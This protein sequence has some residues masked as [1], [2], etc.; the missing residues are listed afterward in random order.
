MVT[1][2]HD[3]FDTR[4]FHKEIAS[5]SKKP[6]LDLTM[7][8]C[9]GLGDT[10]IDEFGVKII[11]HGRAASRLK[12]M[13][14]SSIQITAKVI[15]LRAE[16]VHFHDPEF[17]P[18]ASVLRFFGI[19]SIYDA[20]ENLAA[21]VLDKP[22]IAKKYRR[23]AGVIVQT[24]EQFFGLF[25]NGII[26]ATP[27]IA[28]SFPPLKSLVVQNFPNDKLPSLVSDEREDYF[29][30]AGMITELRGLSTVIDALDLM[31][32]NA[33]LLLIGPFQ[34]DSYRRK[35]EEKPGWSRV[36][37]L[38]WLE[39][40]DLLQTIRK[41]LG[42]VVTFTA[43][44]NHITAQPNKMFEYM[45]CGSPVI[46]SD[47]PLWREIVVD[48]EVGFLVDPTNAYDLS[49]VFDQLFI[50]RQLVLS[51]G[52]NGIDTVIDKFSWQSEEKKLLK[53]YEG[54]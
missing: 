48:N 38:P 22:Y 13:I 19:K 53:F 27:D 2:A 5:L 4:I 36:H 54:L 18:F 11:D 23:I 8:V 21:T 52:Q 9:D 45:S 32:C 16:V 42:G 37:Y 7:H 14:G 35:L 49:Q 30:F 25:M 47:F 29:V 50:N 40:Q 15:K 10:Y 6:N 33:R 1:T 26:C 12:R 20:H 31:E 43:A 34:D 28:L 44:A 24:L 3:R 39:R 51:L 17:L 46:G 41:S